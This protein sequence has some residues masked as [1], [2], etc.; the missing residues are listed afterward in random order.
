MR[1]VR[2]ASQA[3]RLKRL[4]WPPKGGCAAAAPECS[5][6]TILPQTQSLCWRDRHA[7]KLCSRAKR[8]P[9]AAGRRPSAASVRVAPAAPRLRC[10]ASN[11][12]DPTLPVQTRNAMDGSSR[13]RL[14]EPGEARRRVSTRRRKHSALCARD[15][16]AHPS[17]ETETRTTTITRSPLSDPGTSSLTSSCSSRSSMHLTGTGAALCRCRTS[18]RPSSSTRTAC[19][20]LTAM[21]SQISSRCA[22]PAPCPCPPPEILFRRATHRALQCARAAAPSSDGTGVAAPGRCRVPAPDE[23][24]L[25]VRQPG[26]P[27]GFP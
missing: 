16:R 19:Q 1:S 12:H 24:H 15:L 4:A 6:Q 5:Y 25:S 11:A 21:I 8:P 10:R 14:Q 2:S 27:R 22:R 23:G 3:K 7:S 17:L 20:A 9:T 13:R 18:E 26:R